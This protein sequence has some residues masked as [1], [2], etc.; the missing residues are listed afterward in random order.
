MQKAWTLLLSRTPNFGMIEL[1]SGRLLFCCS[2]P[3]QNNPSIVSFFCSELLV[4]PVATAKILFCAL[5]RIV[6]VMETQRTDK[7]K[8]MLFLGLM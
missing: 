3:T 7:S 8:A 4:Y 2:T 1:M 6:V 5:F